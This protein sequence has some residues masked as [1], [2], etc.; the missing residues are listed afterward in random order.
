ML[1]EPALDLPAI[2]TC[3][4]SAYGLE[5]ASF[6]FIRSHDSHAAAYEVRCRDGGSRFLKARFGPVDEP[7]LLVPRALSEAGIAGVLSPIPTRS[8]GVWEPL[9]ALSLVLYPF[10]AG[11]S[12][13][14]VGMSDAQWRSF[15][16][17]L[18]LVHDSSVAPRFSDRLPVETFTLPSAVS[19]RLLLSRAHDREA[20]SSVGDRLAH[21]LRHSG[22]KI[23][24]MLDRAEE[25][26]ATLRSR[27]F[28]L[29][30]CHGDIHAANILVE[31]A[32][33]VHLVDWDGP[34]VAP[35]ERDLLF[36][37]GA[38]VAREVLPREEQLFFEGYGPVEISADALRYYRYERV[39]EDIGSYG[40]SVFE[41]STASEA[42]KAEEAAMVSSFFDVGGIIETAE[43]VSLPAATART[44]QGSG[45][46]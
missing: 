33:P 22:P 14:A 4:S 45:C 24:A 21:F 20:G 2:A 15:G 35:R 13:M 6:R 25:L 18:R 46:C 34:V 43:I 28:E 30:L 19:V 42:V 40:H 32:G 17:T 31:E 8:S 11:T 41:D 3:L 29:V 27:P 36:V 38:R 37:V 39:I 26:G 44:A 7:A 1:G 9:G 23:L 5:V 10:V 16:R 12:A